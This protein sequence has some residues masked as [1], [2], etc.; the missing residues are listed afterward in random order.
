MA[1]FDP[2]QPRN[3]NGE[4]AEAE[5]AARKAAGLSSD[6]NIFSKPLFADFEK[7]G[8]EEKIMLTDM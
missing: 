4:W 5:T 6:G 2:N 3:E 7:Q 8:R 1:G